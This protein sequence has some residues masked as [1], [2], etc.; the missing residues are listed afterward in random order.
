[1]NSPYHNDLFACFNDLNL[2]L[3][4][5]FCPLCLNGQNWARARKEPCHV[6]HVMNI[7]IWTRDMIRREL[8]ETEIHY[9]EDYFTYMFCSCCAI[10]QDHLELNTID[11]GS[12]SDIPLLVGGDS[13]TS[14]S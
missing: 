14:Y 7:P 8:G 4:T 6:C 3:Y 2:C 11:P 12:A 13:Q 1:M 9:V 10:A 5:T